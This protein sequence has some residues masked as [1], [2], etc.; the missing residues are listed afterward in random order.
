MNPRVYVT[1]VETFSAAH[2]LFNT[3]LDKEENTRIFGR[4]AG[5]N[6]HGH[7]FKMEVTVFGEVSPVT[8]MV[9]DLKKLKRIIQTNVLNLV[10]HKNLDLD[11]K[12][13]RETNLVSTSENIA[14]FIWR[15]L[16]S[17]IDSK[18]DLE[19]KLYETESNIF[20]YRGD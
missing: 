3:S 18:M 2:R 19:V 1:R 6:G 16:R 7:N 20:C 13:F 8:G 12:Y 9:I 17:S 10:D 15:S 14:V 4:C 5:E 11:V